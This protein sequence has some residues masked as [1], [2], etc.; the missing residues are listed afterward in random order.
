MVVA[1]IVSSL[2]ARVRPPLVPAKESV[3]ST[4]GVDVFVAVANH[5]I[6]EQRGGGGFGAEQVERGIGRR[7]RHRI[8]ASM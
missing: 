7:C 2:A 6:G 4:N 8:S 5:H 3:P 1:V